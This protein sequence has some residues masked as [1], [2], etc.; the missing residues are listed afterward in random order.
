MEELEKMLELFPEKECPNIN[1]AF[2]KLHANLM[3]RSERAAVSISGG[4]DSDVMMDMIQALNPAKNYPFAAIHYVW[5][6]TGIEYTATKEHLDFLQEKYGVT[7]E[8][9]KAKTPVPVGCKTWGQPFMSK[10]IS[11]YISRL[12]AHNFQWE[13]E[14]F[15]VLYERYP[16]CK[17]ALR[18]WCNEWGPESRMNIEKCR[19]LKEFMIANPPGFNISDGCCKGA[20]KDV[21]HE[22][23]KEIKAT[24]NIVGIRKAE[25]GA[26]AT[27][28]NSCFSEPSSKSEAA[29]FR[30]L[31]FMTDQDKELYCQR[32]GVV[33]SD[34]YEKHGF[35]RTGCACCPFGSRFEQELQAAEQLDP[36]L[37][38]AA[39]RIFGE[40]YEYTR[41]YREFKA[42]HDAERKA[43]GQTSLF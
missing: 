28:Y 5:F 16:N 36:G 37:A 23:L 4:A 33:H 27:A 26:R 21:A 7:I 34:L 2:R 14:P 13:N 3:F 43:N 17:A 11:Q 15:R 25:G 1:S 10:Q 38:V 42:R 18:W 32:R 35:K 6:N 24:I 12:Q 39:K 31:F 41:A 29:Q 22:Y 19:L 30:P 20:K 8:R 40:A 9:K